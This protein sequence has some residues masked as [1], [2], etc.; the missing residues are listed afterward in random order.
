MHH[1]LTLTRSFSMTPEDFTFDYAARVPGLNIAM[2]FIGLIVMIVPALWLVIRI[3]RRFRMETG[4]FFFGL[5]A[6]ILA[7]G[8]VPVLVTAVINR[9]PGG[10]DLLA[11][12]TP[13]R[14]AIYAIFTVGPSFAAIWFGLIF[15]KKR[16]HSYFANAALFGLTFGLIPI[17]TN[18]IPTTVSYISAALNV[19]Q[20]RMADFVTAMLEQETTAAEIQTGLD[21]MTEFIG[22]HPSIFLIEPLS[23]TFQMFFYTGVAILTGGYIGK[24]APRASLIKA[25]VLELVFGVVQI[26]GM[27]F[28]SSLMTII[29]YFVIAAASMYLAWLDARA[30]HHEDWKRFLGKPDPT[31]N[32]PDAGKTDA[33]KKRMPK[34]VMPDK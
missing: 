20:G 32:N 19:N 30:Y 14:A 16:C 25:A 1:F 27:V 15:T 28:D 33:P 24:L 22:I 26:L 12:N 34:I 10:A 23:L 13:L 17:L 29:F 3:M 9:I 4:G 18:G 6:S 5:F 7:L 21:S 2:M 8:M 11:Q 31:V